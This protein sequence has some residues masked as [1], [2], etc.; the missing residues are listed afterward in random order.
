MHMRI[1]RKRLEAAAR[2]ALAEMGY[3]YEGASLI[4]CAESKDPKVFNPRA[5]KA[6][7]SARTILRAAS[8]R[9]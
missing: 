9:T 7:E 4:D 2:V 5:A 1:T 3:L 8:D 6:V